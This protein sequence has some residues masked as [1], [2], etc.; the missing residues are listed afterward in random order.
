[1]RLPLSCARPLLRTVNARLAPSSSR[2]APRCAQI[3]RRT[4][5]SNSDDAASLEASEH[6][7]RFGCYDVILPTEPY[8]WGTA[9]IIPRGVPP[10]ISRPPYA[11]ELLEPGADASTAEEDI[12]TTKRKFITDAEDLVKL[13]R[14]ARLASDVLTFAGSLV[15]VGR[16]TDAM[17]AAVHELVLACG[18]YPSPLRYK[19]FPKACC[20]SVNNVITHG[21][22]DDRPLQDGDIV[23]VDI[24]VYLDGF[25]GDTSRTFLVGEVDEKGRE[26][27]EITEAALEAGISACGPGRPFK[28]IGRAIHE[29][30]KGKDF[31]AS[32]QFTGHG[33]GR[34]FHR[35]PWIYHELNEEPGQMQPGD[36][37][38]IE[39]AIVQ[40][41]EPLGWTFPDGW[42]VST[43]NCARAAQAEHM[44]L[45]TD[46][47]AEVLTRP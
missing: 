10:H 45:I 9:H 22:P 32:P 44:V 35:Q 37:F 33:I 18:A 26:L 29:L 46:S 21:I 43:E 3:F 42:T 20:T 6:D 47:G 31:S 14:A 40:G 8:A 36:C 2:A 7:L 23:N 4:L 34:E 27:V 24:T 28:G 30:L 25:H 19:G 41:T 17:D 15:Q 13:R 11:P 16:T 5:T 1:M 38:T 12:A 39:P